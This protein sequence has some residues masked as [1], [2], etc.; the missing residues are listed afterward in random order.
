[1]PPEVH[2]AI[3]RREASILAYSMN[4]KGTQITHLA[5]CEQFG[6]T[7]CLHLLFMQ[8][9]GTPE[10]CW[11]GAPQSCC[12]PP[13]PNTRGARPVGSLPLRR[14]RI[15]MPG[16]GKRGFLLLKVWSLYLQ[17]YDSTL[18]SGEMATSQTYS[19]IPLPWRSFRKHH[20]IFQRHLVNIIQT[21]SGL[22]P[23]NLSVPGTGLYWR[24]FPWKWQS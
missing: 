12:K 23:K 8:Q 5:A 4:S 18:P 2:R 19:I 1:M 7:V 20:P 22:W 16:K 17:V 6:K 9:T 10:A 3:T 21:N 15:I 24:G 11:L 13:R 14:H